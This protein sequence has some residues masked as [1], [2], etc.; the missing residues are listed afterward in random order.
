MSKL[1]PPQTMKAPPP[2]NFAGHAEGQRCLSVVA[3]LLSGITQESQAFFRLQDRYSVRRDYR[4]LGG[5]GLSFATGKTPVRASGNQEVG[6][7]EDTTDDTLGNQV[8][9]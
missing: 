3:W 7:D 5:S 4:G 1:N 6:R 2:R 9:G 8:A